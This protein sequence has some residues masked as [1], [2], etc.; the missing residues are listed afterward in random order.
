MVALA[1]QARSEGGNLTPEQ[2]AQ[3]RAYISR[4]QELQNTAQ[5]RPAAQPPRPQTIDDPET[6]RFWWGPV[7]RRYYPREYEER[8]IHD[9]YYWRPWYYHNPVPHYYRYG[10]HSPHIGTGVYF[11]VWH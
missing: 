10:P 3:V 1:H 8:F 6:Q 7:G 11:N 9:P 2:L 5:A 4:W